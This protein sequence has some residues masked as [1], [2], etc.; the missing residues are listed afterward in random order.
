MLERLSQENRMKLADA[1]DSATSEHAVYFLVTAYVE[2]LHHFHRSLG[3]PERTIALPVSGVE[4]LTERLHLV[5]ENVDP[6][7]ESTLGAAE[8]AAILQCALG[9]LHALSDDSG[10]LDPERQ[11]TREAA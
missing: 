10:V 5:R 7:R 9:R 6:A 4:D 2:S 3:V 11:T 8:M 1:I